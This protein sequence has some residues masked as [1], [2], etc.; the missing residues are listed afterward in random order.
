MAIFGISFKD[1][2][3][4]AEL[5]RLI[6]DHEHQIVFGIGKA[7]TGKDFASISCALHLYDNNEYGEIYYARNPVQCGEDMGFLPG[8]VVEKYS[9]FMEPLKDTVKSIVRK[10]NFYEKKQKNEQKAK[11]ETIVKQ[12]NCLPLSFIRGRTLDDAIVIIDECQNLDAMTLRTIMTRL[13]RNAKLVLLG[14]YN[15]IDDKKQQKNLQSKGKCDFQKV[16]EWFMQNKDY[17][18]GVELVK[19]MRSDICV[20]IDESFDEIFGGDDN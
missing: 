18:A 12:I 14:S 2:P 11:V 4:Q 10:S 20:D 15:Q 3:E 1:N 6:M 19:S 7:G 9:P 8:D 17:A 13:G 5:V 16:A